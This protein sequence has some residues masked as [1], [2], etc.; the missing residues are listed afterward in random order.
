MRILQEVIDLKD[1]KVLL[2]VDFDIPVSDQGQIE[3][4]FRIRKQKETLDYLIDHGA[5][6]VMIGHI[7]DQSVEQSFAALMPQ[8]HTLLGYEINFLKT[9]SINFFRSS[10]EYPDKNTEFA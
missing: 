9:V 1:K 6:V 4:A 3:E 8:L 10:C 5:K 2:R 7:S